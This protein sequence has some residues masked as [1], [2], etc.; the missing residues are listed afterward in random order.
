MWDYSVKFLVCG[1]LSIHPRHPL[2]TD[3]SCSPER[4]RQT[5]APV[6]PLLH[7]ASRQVL[8]VETDADLELPALGAEA[9]TRHALNRAAA[10]GSG[11]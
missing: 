11:M 4:L 3:G 5:R 8:G 10:S 1:S 6:E 2:P 7:A 9:Q